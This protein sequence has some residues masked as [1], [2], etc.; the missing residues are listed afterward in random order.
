MTHADPAVT[1]WTGGWDSTYRLLEAVVI[2][3]RVVQPIYVINRARPNTDV[4][5]QTMDKIR[6]AVLSQYG[7]DVADL[8]RP[9]R[10]FHHSDIPEHAGVRAAFNAIVAKRHLGIQYMWLAEFCV[11]QDTT[12]LELGMHWI[13]RWHNAPCRWILEN[14]A[15]DGYTYRIKDV[16]QDPDIA[17]VLGRYS[18]PI[19]PMTK[20]HM[21]AVA[22]Y[23]GFS[24]LMGM[25]FFCHRP[26]RSGDPC[27][28]CTPCTTAIK[29][30]MG[31]RIPLRNRY[32]HKLRPLVQPVRK[33]QKML[34]S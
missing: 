21:G 22:T 3:K 18:F 15:F 5:L 32:K 26:T 6:Q 11:W 19:L 1:L 13:N 10:I 30:G 4:E 33:L 17:M 28:L 24:N 16:P 27:G 29:E 14:S 8:I 2:E 31:W 20:D 12:D 23:Y 9:T 25:T 34:R 7:V